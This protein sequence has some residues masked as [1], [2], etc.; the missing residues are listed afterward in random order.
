MGVGVKRIAFLVFAVLLVAGGMPLVA[1]A[2]DSIEVSGT[3]VEV[4]IDSIDPSDDD[5]TQLA[6]DTGEELLPVDPTSGIGVRAG[7]TVDGIVPRSEDEVLVETVRQLPPSRTASKAALPV[8]EV[9]VIAAH[10]EDDPVTPAPANETAETIDGEVAEFWSA[11]TDSGLEFEVADVLDVTLPGATPAGCSLY[12]I[13]NPVLAATGISGAAN[14]HVV[15]ALQ[16]AKGRECGWAGIASRPSRVD[17]G[18]YVLLN[19]DYRTNTKV[20]A[21]ELGHNVTLG[22]AAST[23]CVNGDGVAVPES[24]Q[25]VTTTYGDLYDV[26]GAYM[27]SIVEPSPV[28]L[29]RLGMADV[30]SPAVSTSGAQTYQLRARSSSSG[31]RAIKVVDG[32]A[33]YW[34]EYRTAT[35]YS[36]WI[37]PKKGKFKTTHAL[38]NRIPG[39]TPS[40]AGVFVRRVEP[41]TSSSLGSRVLDAT[42]API[43]QPAGYEGDIFMFAVRPNDSLI[44]A[45]SGVRIT[46]LDATE[47]VAEVRVDH[48]PLVTAANDTT[49]PEPFFARL[50]GRAPVDG[51]GYRAGYALLKWKAAADIESGIEHY[52]LVRDG[53]RLASIDPGGYDREGFYWGSLKLADGLH[54]YAVQAVDLAGN[55]TESSPFRILSDVERPVF[56][57]DP[58][59]TLR[60]GHVEAVDG[61]KSS[62]RV[63]V[64]LRWQVDDVGGAGLHDEAEVNVGYYFRKFENVVPGR[65][66]LALMTDQ[67]AGLLRVVG[68]GVRDRAGNRAWAERR[69]VLHLVSQARY[70][71]SRGWQRVSHSRA[72]GTSAIRTTQRGSSVRIRLGSGQ[73]GVIA[74]RGPAQGAIAI[75]LDGRKVKTIDLRG[76][77]ARPGQLVWVSPDFRSD[78]H[79]L[80]IVS[81]SSRPV[82]LDELA[83]LKQGRAVLR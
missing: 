16:S 27:P 42:P 20:I 68:V 78:R 34:L 59:V 57:R 51:I 67:P 81:T 9:I 71:A 74:N 38:A 53:E 15:I 76:P 36:T 48:Q 35:S 60:T 7:M 47:D 73:T 3:V 22:H 31:M 79:R 33:E 6:L 72:L 25:C 70:E 29:D 64:Q 5:A 41:S 69:A 24:T 65:A 13:V 49:P 14:R 58:M 44:T 46:V 45:S 77:D 12:N 10:W 21:H 37:D 66:N 39:Y 8:H 17:V 80:R 75:F 2:S 83:K 28:M 82:V 11:T 32:S 61:H 26:M 63:P 50:T 4:V 56:T 23:S 30:L 18:G 54:D 1:S 43:S 19:R 55:V 52:Y 62:Y 40:R